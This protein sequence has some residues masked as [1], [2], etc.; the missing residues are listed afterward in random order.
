MNEKTNLKYF[1]SQGATAY[2]DIAKVQ[3]EQDDQQTAKG[4]STDRPHPDQKV[5]ELIRELSYGYSCQSKYR[6]FL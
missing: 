6:R 2:P 4:P 5:S 3:G 1:A